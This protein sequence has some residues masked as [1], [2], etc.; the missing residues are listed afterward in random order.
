MNTD[1]NKEFLYFSNKY[2]KQLH[3]KIIKQG[4]NYNENMLYDLNTA[5]NCEY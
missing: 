5:I 3:W 4:E 2:I 1:T